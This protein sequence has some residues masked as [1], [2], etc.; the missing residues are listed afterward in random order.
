MS[1]VL[2]RQEELLERYS[3]AGGPSFEGRTRAVLAETSL[4]EDELGLPTATLSGGQRKLVALA[5][6]L[7]Q[8]PDVLL[9]DEPEAHLDLD[10]RSELESLPSGYDG[11]VVVVS[12]DRYLL[13][14]TA[15]RRFDDWARRVA[16]ERHIKQARVKRRQIDRMETVE[17]PVL[18]RRKITLAL[19][20]TVRG[21]DRELRGVDVAF[22]D[23]PVL[24]GVGLTVLRGERVGVVG[25]NGAGKSVLLEVLAG[26]LAPTS[27]DRWIGPSIRVGSLGQ[28]QAPANPAATPLEVVMLAPAAPRGRP[29]RS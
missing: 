12:H 13:D 14:E 21:G 1:R 10:A 5:C 11:A 27:G 20:P 19:R 26:G 28:E 16:N 24:L 2:G 15:I 25:D 22:G 18:E 3:A 7:A 9:L 6:C 17:R 8:E 4:T 23:H 29:W